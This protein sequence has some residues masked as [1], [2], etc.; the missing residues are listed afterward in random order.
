MREDIGR[1]ISMG[2][3]GLEPHLHSPRGK[4][5][6]V[7]SLISMC[8]RSLAGVLGGLASSVMGDAMD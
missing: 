5:R 4:E 1:D 3:A 2:K 7:S 8:V 6:Q